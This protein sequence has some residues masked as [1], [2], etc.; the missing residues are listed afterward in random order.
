MESIALKPLL[1]L[2]T[3]HTLTP[4]QNR[5]IIARIESSRFKPVN[6]SLSLENELTTAWRFF[7]KPAAERGQVGLGPNLPLPAFYLNYQKATMANVYRNFLPAMTDLKMAG[8]GYP[9]HADPCVE[10]SKCP[11]ASLAQGLTP[12][13]QRAAWQYAL[14]MTKLEALRTI[15]ALQLYHHDHHAWPASLDLLVGPYLKTAPTSYCA[16]PDGKGDRRF[17]YELRSGKP[18]LTA[19]T[20]ESRPGNGYSKLQVLFPYDASTR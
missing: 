8:T 3:A 5:S 18:Y 16:T 4:E 7:D 6:L 10:L 2:E 12:N 13:C 17:G 9:K 14:L 1:M 19:P 15:A 11:M 20:R